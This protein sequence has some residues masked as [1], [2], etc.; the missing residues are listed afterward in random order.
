MANKYRGEVALPAFGE[1]AFICFDLDDLV[2]LERQFGQSFFDAVEQAVRP[3][4]PEKMQAIIRIGLRRRTDSGEVERIGETVD[5]KK[6]HGAGLNLADVAKPM[7]DALSESYIGKSYDDLVKE[8]EAARKDQMR[9]AIAD[10][11]EAASES[12]V[13]FEAL[14]SALLLPPT[15]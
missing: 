2:A 12:D 10:A 4:S 11:K 7:L 8:A 14:L 15:A 9:R 3:P 1:G 6:H 13:P 5:L